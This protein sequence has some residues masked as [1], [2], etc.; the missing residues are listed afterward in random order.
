MFTF[1]ISC[2]K[3]LLI[4]ILILILILKQKTVPKSYFLTNQTN[5]STINIH[6]VAV[7]WRL[8]RHWMMRLRA[9]SV[10]MVMSVPQ[11]SLSMLATIPTT[12]IWFAR[13]ALFEET[14]SKWGLQQRL[15][16]GLIVIVV[17]L[18]IILFNETTALLWRY[19]YLRVY[20]NE[21][22]VIN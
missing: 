19:T 3:L 15:V 18:V 9:V 12:F 8:S 14:L 11:K 20:V 17:V 5:S 2:F 22:I 16:V 10:P 21:S 7:V 4:L 1:Y 13:E 6:L